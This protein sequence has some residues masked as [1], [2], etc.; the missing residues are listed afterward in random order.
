[1]KNLAAVHT[2][3]LDKVQARH[4]QWRPSWRWR[5]H[6]RLSNM[7]QPHRR[8][9][10]SSCSVRTRER[11]TRWARPSSRRWQS[12]RSSLQQAPANRTKTNRHKWNV[13]QTACWAVEAAVRWSYLDW[14]VVW[15][16]HWLWLQIWLQFIIKEV[17]DKFLEI[18]HAKRD[19][20]FI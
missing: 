19:Q 6:F 16:W 5:Y 12:R 1:M 9:A 20:I 4:W 17:A 7:R 15:S 11:R 2:R 18:I 13:L 8:L 3:I 10:P 14:F